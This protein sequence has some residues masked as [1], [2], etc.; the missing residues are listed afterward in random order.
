MAVS[1]ADGHNQPGAGASGVSYLGAG[2]EETRQRLDTP[3]AELDTIA[4]AGKERPRH[5]G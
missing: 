4:T 3:L 2:A 5:V 1:D